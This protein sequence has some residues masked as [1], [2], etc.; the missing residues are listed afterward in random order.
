M[1][2]GFTIEAN[3]IDPFDIEPNKLLDALQARVNYLRQH[4]G[5][6]LEALGYSDSYEVDRKSDVDN[7]E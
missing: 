1:D 7:G 5:E 4:P 3:Q 2:V 6:I